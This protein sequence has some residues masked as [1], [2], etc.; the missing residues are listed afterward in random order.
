MQLD[1]VT[2]AFPDP[3]ALD[4]AISRVILDQVAAGKRNATFRLHRPPE[5]VAFGRHDVIQPG[6]G[7][8]VSA[9]RHH[10]FEA[11]ERLAGG[12][13][14]VFHHQTLAFSWASPEPEP[15]SRI[16]E[17]FTD[18]T[19]V[20]L[21]AF[22]ELGLDA[23]VGEV[24]GEYCPGRFSINIGGRSKVAGVGQRLVRGAAHVGGVIVCAGHQRINQVLEP[25][26]DALDLS[27]DPSATGSIA[28]FVPVDVEA[29]AR[30]VITALG[31]RHDIR[32]VELDESTRRAGLL[33]M[34]EHLAQPTA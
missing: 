2:T 16:S 9:A 19:S 4:T 21:D 25:V 31:I 6:Y 24:S 30:S 27:F 3:P 26:Y 22:R 34:H 20:L 23:R 10:G 11:I 7:K 33:L 18:T 15:L 32:P 28:E 12:R 17:R 1:L 14:A 5:I 8:A 13:A 29:V